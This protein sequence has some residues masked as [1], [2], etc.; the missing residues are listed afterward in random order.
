MAPIS[1]SAIDQMQV[2]IAPFDVRQ[3]N[4]VGASVNTVT[5]S[6]TN[7]FHGSFSDAF[8]TNSLV[9]TNARGATVNPGTFNFRNTGGW[10]SGPIK[11][12]TAFFFA[13]Y[14]N[15]A[16]TQPGTTFRANLG[17]EPTTGSVTRVLASDLDPLRL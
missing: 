7:E 6:G 1:L 2:N 8:R 5:R 3:G 17:G 16:F 15:E 10:A 14:E 12:D 11:R 13:D 9:G 4:F